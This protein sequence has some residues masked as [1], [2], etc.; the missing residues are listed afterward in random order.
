MSLK[1]LTK[2]MNRLPQHLKEKTGNTSDITSDSD[3]TLILNAFRVFESSIQNVH[4]SGNKYAKQLQIMLEQLCDYC[5]HI[6]DV[7]RGDLAGTPV[8]SSENV[9][10]PVEITSVKSCIEGIKV[11]IQPQL[12]ELLKIIN[13][14]EQVIKL[15]QGIEKTLIK[16]DHKRVDYDRYKVDVVEMDKRKANNTFTVKEEK[17][18]QEV[19]SKFNTAEYEYNQIHNELKQQLPMLIQLKPTLVE[20]VLFQMFQIQ[21]QL[22]SLLANNLPQSLCQTPLD[23]LLSEIESADAT[24]RQL[25]TISGTS[26]ASLGRQ[27][28]KNSKNNSNEKLQQ[29]SASLPAV[30]PMRPPSDVR[31]NPFESPPKYEQDLQQELAGRKQSLNGQQ[32]MPQVNK[33]TQQPPQPVQSAPQ[34]MQQPQYPSAMGAAPVGANPWAT[35]QKPPTIAPKPQSNN[36]TAIAL[37]DFPGQE[38][39]DLSFSKGDLITVIEKTNSVD[40]WWKGKIGNRTGMFPANYCQLK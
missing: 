13:K 24:I 20:P 15:N 12:D 30:Q 14:L 19:S 25:E 38:Q 4:L 2:A 27:N 31:Q 22:Y 40:D 3:Y 33:P 36:L 39:G 32:I 28:S 34:P 1:G 23:Q 11:Q 18:Y 35:Q 17:K 37:F 16:R 26:P 6:E 5:E 10:T 29:S 7:L 9:M 8:Q 21:S